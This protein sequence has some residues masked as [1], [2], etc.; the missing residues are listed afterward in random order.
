MIH[1]MLWIPGRVYA[2]DVYAESEAEAR[3]QYRE[4]YGYGRLPKGTQVWEKVE[5]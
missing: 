1:F 2:S 3:R 5:P 4:R